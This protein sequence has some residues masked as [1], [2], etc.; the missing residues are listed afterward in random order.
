M[1]V[2]KVRRPSLGGPQAHEGTG[3]FSGSHPWL[4]G[5]RKEGD[6]SESRLRMP[7]RGERIIHAWCDLRVASR[8]AVLWPV[9]LQRSELRRC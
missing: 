4:G 8:H 7:L 1:G 5:G 3:G 9:P 2:M 6:R